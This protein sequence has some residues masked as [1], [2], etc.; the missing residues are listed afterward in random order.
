[1]VRPH[2]RILP[3]PSSHRYRDSTRRCLPTRIGSSGAPCKG[4]R[5]PVGIGNSAGSV[6]G[7]GFGRLGSRTGASGGSSFSGRGRGREGRGLDGHLGGGGGLLGGGG[8][9]SSGRGQSTASKCVTH[10]RRA[11]RRF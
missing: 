6:G 2:E 1:K 5:E 7:C 11:K 10:D 3:A 4:A 8:I 9:S